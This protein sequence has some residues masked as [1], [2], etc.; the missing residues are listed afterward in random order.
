MRYLSFDI[1]ATGLEKHDL[2]IEFGMV[3]FDTDKKELEL[4]LKKH[5]FIKCPSF[6]ELKPQ[7][8]PWVIEHNE[9]LIIQ[10]HQEGI[11]IENFK[12]E[13]NNYFSSP[14]VKNYF[15]NKPIILFGKSLNAID[16]PF[17]HRDLGEDFMRRY[18]SHR[19]NDLS[20]FAYNLIDLKVL[21]PEAESGSWLA[22][23][24]GIGEVA[25]TALEDAINTVKMYFLLLD[26]V[27]SLTKKV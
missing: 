12:Q 4:N 13:L 10:A 2:I 14:E 26:R 22:Q 6:E 1:E 17:L 15:G 8:N 19:V 9:Q 21:P 3:P 23:H 24:L 11:T 16:L 20:S 18:F 25:H 27:Q 7:L 5:F